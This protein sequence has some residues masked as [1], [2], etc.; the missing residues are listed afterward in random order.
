MLAP[1]SGNDSVILRL[2]VSFD[3]FVRSE[4]SSESV[5]LRPLELE[6]LPNSVVM[7]LKLVS[8]E[9]ESMSLAVTALVCDSPG[10]VE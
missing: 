6:Y 10:C 4:S 9:S 7:S 2:G 3:Q 8:R 5:S 1:E